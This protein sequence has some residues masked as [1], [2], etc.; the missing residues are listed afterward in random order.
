MKDDELYGNFSKEEA[1]K[2]EK[3]AKERWGSTE[4]YKQSVER[5]AKMR[6]D[7]IKKVMEESSKITLDIAQ[8][9][10][11]GSSA[12]NPEVQKLFA[13]H[14]DWLRAFYEPSLDIYEGLAKMYVD[15]PRFKKTYEDIAVGLAVYMREGMLEYVRVNR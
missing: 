2:Y 15:D 14:Y 8:S 3:E 1:E 7:G 4:A 13:K 5:V 9:M 11:D 6:K 12:K 10:K